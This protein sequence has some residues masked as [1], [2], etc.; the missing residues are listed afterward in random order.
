MPSFQI[1]GDKMKVKETK[2]KGEVTKRVT[3]PEC[4]EKHTYTFVGLGT[5]TVVCQKNTRVRFQI[6]V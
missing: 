2:T 1:K 3:C 6:K 5:Q 4:K